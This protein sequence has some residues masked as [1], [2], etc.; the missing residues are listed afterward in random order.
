M[1]KIQYRNAQGHV[2]TAQSFDRAEIQKLAD[3]AR[4]DVPDTSVCQLRVREVAADETTG[5]FIW[6]DCTD[7]FTR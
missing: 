5:D 3:K 2:V 1:F 7:D 6:A 4:Q